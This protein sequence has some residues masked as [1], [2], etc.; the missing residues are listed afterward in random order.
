MTMYPVLKTPDGFPR[1][2]TDSGRVLEPS[3]G[4][5]D[6]GW[7]I[8]DVPP[9]RWMNWLQ[10]LS[11]EWA[12]YNM[13]TL[14]SNWEFCNFTTSPTR[15]DS[16]IWHPDK[17]IWF[18]CAHDVTNNGEIWTS[19]DGCQYTLDENLTGH[20]PAD[21]A[22][23][24]DSSYAIVAHDDGISY[25][26]ENAV[27][28]DVLNA[29]IGISTGPQTITTKYDTSDLIIVNYFNE[30]YR[31]T[32]GVSGGSWAAASTQPSSV[33]AGTKGKLLYTTGSTVYLMRSSTTATKTYVSTDDGD[34][35]AATTNHPLASSQGYD[36]AYNPDSGRLIVCGA[37]AIGAG[38]PLIEYS[39]DG[40]V[41]SWSSTTI[42]YGGTT[43]VAAAVHTIYY[44]GNNVWVAAGSN[45]TIPGTTQGSRGAFFISQDDG[46]TWTQSYI[47][48]DSASFTV[49][50]GIVE[51]IAFS[52]QFGAAI[53]PD[54]VYISQR[55][56]AY[57]L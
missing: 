11:Y 33:P 37:T 40:G 6:T 24:I 51:H 36:M 28:T 10:N 19:L 54:G 30:V 13:R 4:V 32:T 8:D 1:W 43:P 50:A 57:N 5:K 49:G 16:I 53:N 29:T 26:V 27:W 52:P 23:A 20:L 44:C 25:G 39:N 42:D 56:A 55:N 2:A 17:G 48:E 47:T 46:E 38:T 34:N 7:Q 14:I 22:I 15:C 9:A 3:S 41:T 31:E 18:L 35:W 21:R 45:S 12:Q